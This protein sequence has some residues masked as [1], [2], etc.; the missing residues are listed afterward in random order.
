MSMCH[1]A[2]SLPFPV[3]RYS[4]FKSFKKLPGIECLECG[5][6]GELFV[7]TGE[8]ISK[9]KMLV[10][11]VHFCLAKAFSVLFVFIYI[12]CQILYGRATIHIRK[13]KMV[14]LQLS[15]NKPLHRMFLLLYVFSLSL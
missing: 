12:A 10:V 7:S 4:F 13:I 2:M 6:T 15:T 5:Y 9:G 14:A 3:G 8:I 11:A 1:T